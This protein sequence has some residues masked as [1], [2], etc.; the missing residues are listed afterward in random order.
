MTRYP[1]QSN[2]T[3]N[4]KWPD[5][6]W[7]DIRPDTKIFIIMVKVLDELWKYYLQTPAHVLE[8]SY[9]TFVS[10]VQISNKL[11]N[12]II[13]VNNNLF[14][15]NNKVTIN[16]NIN[17]DIHQIFFYQQFNISFKWNLYCMDDNELRIEERNIKEFNSI[18]IKMKHA[19]LKH[20]SLTN[21][22]WSD[23]SELTRSD[24]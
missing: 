3:R 8:D 1:I 9:V 16:Y 15:L 4:L 18:E 7:S 23:S 17:Y 6:I 5:T 14:N 22:I 20:T 12:L 11:N 13:I 10:P 24:T 19:W 21:S 2:T